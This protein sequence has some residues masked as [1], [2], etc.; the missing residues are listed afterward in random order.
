MLYKYLSKINRIEDIIRNNRLYAS[1]YT[2]LNDPM[3]GIFKHRGLHKKI[4]KKLKSDKG[5]MRI[6]SLSEKCDD[7]LMWAFY[8]NGE[9]GV[10]IGINRNSI[11][12][13][14]DIKSIQYQEIP[15][16]D[17]G[18]NIIVEDIL[19]YKKE[20]WKHEKE[21]RVFTRDEYVDVEIEEIILGSRIRPSNEQR[22][23]NLIEKAGLVDKIKIEKL[24][25]VLYRV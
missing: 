22:I 7:A 24:E 18:D 25:N 6:C 15:C 1:T 20:E 11:R 16:Y 21:V 14:Y 3:E 8:A 10:V 19:S 9:R 13:V 2:N 12:D 5:K 17:S 4:L 23:R